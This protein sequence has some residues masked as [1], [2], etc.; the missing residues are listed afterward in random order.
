MKKSQLIENY[1]HIDFSKLRDLSINTGWGNL[2]DCLF[3]AINSHI[4]YEL[5]NNQTQIVVAPIQVKEKFG[6]LRFY[7]QGTSDPVI[8][9]MVKLAER[10][11]TKTCDVC[12]QPGSI[13]KDLGWIR[14]LCDQHHQEIKKS[15]DE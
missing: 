10:L 11:S 2:V 14:T 1:P 15:L 7:Y 6:Q 3:G 13:R 8:E 9:G 12:G 5:K 4:E